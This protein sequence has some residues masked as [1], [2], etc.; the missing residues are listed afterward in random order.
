M[1]TDWR[2]LEGKRGVN[3]V[4]DVTVKP[5]AMTALD[6]PSQRRR[7][8]PSS[9]CTRHGAAKQGKSGG[10]VGTTSRGKG[11]GSREARKGQGGRGRTRG[12]ERWFVVVRG[13][14]WWLD[15]RNSVEQWMAVGGGWGGGGW[16]LAVGGW[17]L[18]ADDPWRLP[19]TN[20]ICGP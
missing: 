5:H 15:H 12:G 17:R 8:L 7:Q 14:S 20:K 9:V 2:R 16:R 13:G 19:L 1:V 6:A 18:A 3:N 10:P 4:S 11:R